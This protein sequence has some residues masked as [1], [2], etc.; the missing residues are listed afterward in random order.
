LFNADT[1]F[2]LRLAMLAAMV[3]FGAAVYFAIAWWTGALDV[4]ALKQ[5]FS[6]KS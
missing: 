2:V 5:S 3:G 1:W 4:A 6:R